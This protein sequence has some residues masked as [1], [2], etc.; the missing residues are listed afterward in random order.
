[1]SNSQTGPGLGARLFSAVQYPLP[2]HL[3]SRLVHWLTRLSAGPVHRMA[4]RLFIRI[5][6]VDRTDALNP[7]PAQY[8]SFN[9]FFTRALKPGARVIARGSPR[10][11]SPVDGTVSQLGRIESGQLIQAKGQDYSLRDLLLDDSLAEEF[12]QGRFVTIY[13]A[14]NNY[15]RIHMPAGGKLRATHYL[16]GRLFS[17]NQATAACVPGLFARNERVVCVFDSENGPFAMVL[18]GALFVGSIETVWAGEITP[19][20][21]RRPTRWQCG[22]QAAGH[23]PMTLMQGAEMGRFNMG[24]TV[25]LLGAKAGSDWVGDLE[26]GKAVTMGEALTPA[27]EAAPSD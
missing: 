7:D 17:V 1:M 25:I 16:P 22:E 23:R 6:G 3:L 21:A 27:R 12:S 15:H 24:S 14:P 9:A 2:H 8:G 26:P 13:L 20:T 10:F 11:V 19:G 18:V 5:M 4:I